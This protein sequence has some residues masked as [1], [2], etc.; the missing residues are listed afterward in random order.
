MLGFEINETLGNCI[1]N[2]FFLRFFSCI[3][4]YNENPLC[5]TALHNHEQEKCMFHCVARVCYPQQTELDSMA[6][7]M[8]CVVHAPIRLT[9]CES[10]SCSSNCCAVTVNSRQELRTILTTITLFTRYYLL[11]VI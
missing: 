1:L 9:V 3:D 8:Q 10:C 4:I 11:S 2:T 6:E 5:E 7:L